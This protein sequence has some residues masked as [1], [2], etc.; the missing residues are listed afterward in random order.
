[1]PKLKTA[2]QVELA[3]EAHAFADRSN[4]FAVDQLLREHG[5]T[6]YKRS[7]GCTPLWLRKNTWYSQQAAEDTL[8]REA[9]QLAKMRQSGYYRV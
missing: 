8:P 2:A 5:F 4:R 9:L 1:M 7:K 3:N 6:I